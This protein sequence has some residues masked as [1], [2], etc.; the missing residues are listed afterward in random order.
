MHLGVTSKP[1]QT[2]R[3]PGMRH[4]R[5]IETHI[6]LVILQTITR[7][8]D[9]LEKCIRIRPRPQQERRKAL[10]RR[11]QCQ[12]RRKARLI[13][14]RPAP[15]N[16]AARTSKESSRGKKKSRFYLYTRSVCARGR[17]FCSGSTLRCEAL[18]RGGETCSVTSG[19]ASWYCPRWFPCIH[20]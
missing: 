4:Q 12:K 19:V 5:N 15:L 10:R 17:S 13:A 2:C 1:L 6:L 20:K 18:L 9:S 7:L 11:P 8:A 14:L 16:A 3:N